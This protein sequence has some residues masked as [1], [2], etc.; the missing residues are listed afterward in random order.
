[1][2]GNGEERRK[3]R[4]SHLCLTCE[5]KR[6]DMKRKFYYFYFYTHINEGER[7]KIRTK[8][9]IQ[10]IRGQKGGLHFFI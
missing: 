5:G 7:Y 2:F 3:E 8:I 10:M 4:R 1:M 6:K 9:K